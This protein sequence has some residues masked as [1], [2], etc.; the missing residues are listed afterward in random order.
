MTA[1]R[2]HHPGTIVG[3][4]DQYA[5]E[6]PSRVW[7]TVPVDE[8]DLSKGF[9]DVTYTQLATAVNHVALWMVDHL[10]NPPQSFDTIAYAGPKDVR[11]PIIELATAK[12]GRKVND[13]SM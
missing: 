12:V 13:S 6:D 3:L 10:P 7:A 4:V 11:Y 2:I 8:S 1:N 5:I 9:K